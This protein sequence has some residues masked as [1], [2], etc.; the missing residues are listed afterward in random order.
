MTFDIA[1]NLAS[2][3]SSALELTGSPS[4]SMALVLDNGITFDR[5]FN[6]YVIYVDYFNYMRSLFNQHQPRGA[7]DVPEDQFISDD[8]V[9]PSA[10]E[11]RLKMLRQPSAT[12]TPTTSALGAKPTVRSLEEEM[13]ANRS[14]RGKLSTKSKLF[15]VKSCHSSK[16]KHVRA[17]FSIPFFPTRFLG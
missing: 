1:I 3:T 4:T 10:R 15:M 7:G 13:L 11:I 5:Y 16:P 12:A 14:S 2:I 17:L 9:L 6:L 8:G